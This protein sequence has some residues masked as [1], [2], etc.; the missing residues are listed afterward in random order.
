MHKREQN[1]VSFQYI[2]CMS[3]RGI[4]SPDRAFYGLQ[5]S[6]FSYF[7]WGLQSSQNRQ[8]KT[9]ALESAPYRSISMLMENNI[10]VFEN[11]YF[12]TVL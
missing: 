2:E 10:V 9:D 7:I 12:H 4:C 1:I 6:I 11:S 3:K 8:M 5:N